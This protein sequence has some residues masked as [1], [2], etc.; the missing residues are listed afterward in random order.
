MSK[1]NNEPSAYTMTFYGQLVNLKDLFGDD[2]LY[3]LDLSAYDHD[4]DGATIL[5]GFNQNALHGGD[6][7]YP[8]M[9]PKNNWFYDSGASAHS[10]ANIA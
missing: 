3:D 10:P 4:Y 5:S 6:I 2:Y 1:K 8:L 9:S 7:F